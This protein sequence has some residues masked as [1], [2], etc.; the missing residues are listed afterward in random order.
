MVVLKQGSP[1]SAADFFCASLYNQ[2]GVKTPKTRVLSMSE[3]V[4]LLTAMRAV[5]Y[6]EQ[7]AGAVLQDPRA[8]QAGGTLQEFVRG[9][10]VKDPR[11]TELFE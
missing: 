1:G 7:G 10:T 4:E 5:P 9:Y 8:R 3:W 2:L 6:T 11:A